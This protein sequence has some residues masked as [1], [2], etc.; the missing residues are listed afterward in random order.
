[1]CKCMG[2]VVHVSYL[3][4][5]IYNIHIHHPHPRY[6]NCIF[7]YL[8]YYRNPANRKTERQ[9]QR[10]VV[11]M[12]TRILK[13]NQPAHSYFPFPFIFLFVFVFVFVTN[14]KVCIHY[15]TMHYTQYTSC[16]LRALCSRKAEARSAARSA[17]QVSVHFG[18]FGLYSARR[19]I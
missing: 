19:F 8:Y 6:C 3:L 10:L 16:C 1:M 12:I 7:L 9:R 13:L 2:F 11:I 15:N 17:W 5:T 14:Y 4:S 18:G